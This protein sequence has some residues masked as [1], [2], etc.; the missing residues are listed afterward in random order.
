MKRF[1]LLIP[2]ILCASSLHAAEYHTPNFTVYATDS[3]LAKNIGD[4]AEFYRAKHS[5]EWLGAEI[6]KWSAPC[7]IRVKSGN[8]G[9][10]GATTFSFDRGHVFGWDMQIQGL[11]DRLQ[12][13]VVPHEVLHMVFASHFRRALPRWADEGA[14]TYAEVHRADRDLS[15]FTA[16]QVY[17]SQEQI[18]IRSMLTAYEYPQGRRAT[19]VLYGQGF[20]FA[21]YLID[22]KG[23]NEYV[24]FLET[25]FRSND[26]DLAFHQHYGQSPEQAYS[27]AVNANRPLSDALEVKLVIDSPCIYCDKAKA[28]TV[29][30]LKKKGVKVSYVNKAD[31]PEPVDGAPVFLLYRNGKRVGRVDGFNPPEVIMTAF[32]SSQPETVQVA[33]GIGIGYFGPIGGGNAG[34]KPNPHTDLSPAQTQLVNQIVDQRSQLAIDAT[35]TARLSD[36]KAVIDAQIKAAILEIQANLTDE[37]KALINATSEQ[38]AKIAGFTE[39]IAAVEAGK[40]K[41]IEDH[42]K[43]LEE[44]KAKREALAA[45]VEATKKAAVEAQTE[46]MTLKEKVAGLAKQTISAGLVSAAQWASVTI[47]GFG[48]L[49]Y[50]ANVIGKVMAVRRKEDEA[51]NAAFSDAKVNTKT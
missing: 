22:K 26:W 36:L 39:Q 24:K 18:P 13:S 6:P 38:K 43:A 12:D 10:G 33:Q 45:E 11:P 31:S 15:R 29:P 20:L 51:N 9:N 42:Q 5:K 25:Y 19:A 21:E 48:A 28:E 35:I 27:V 47:P 40:A 17:G 34:N 37:Q 16:K 1:L 8:V 4:S 46:N 3:G 41:F 30:I 23:K 14:A 50:L 32:Q 49:G 7:P 2:L 44:E